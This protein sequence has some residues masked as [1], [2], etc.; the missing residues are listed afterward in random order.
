MN[1]A[2]VPKLISEYVLPYA[3]SRAT[4]PI[5]DHLDSPEVQEMLALFQPALKRMFRFFASA[6]TKNETDV[7]D[8]HPVR[9]DLPKQQQSLSMEGF[10]YF[11]NTFNITSG[12]RAT[13]SAV[14]NLDLAAI[15]FDSIAVSGVDRVG[16]LNFE[17]FWEAL[18]RCALTYYI[19]LSSQKRNEQVEKQMESRQLRRC[20]KH[21]IIDSKEP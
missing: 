1:H 13:A 20:V 16:G 10:V 11:A 5:D 9:P 18:V 14:S 15:F 7:L 2:A 21:R 3:S 19:Q 8:R 6:P 17:E 12:R 4:V